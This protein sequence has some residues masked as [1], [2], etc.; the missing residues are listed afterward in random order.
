MDGYG[1]MLWQDACPYVCPSVTRRYYVETA[2]HI[3]KLF[4]PGRHEHHSTVKPGTHWRQ[5]RLLPIRSTLSPMCTGLYGN[6]PTET[7]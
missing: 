5:S 2:K 3:V 1:T 6:I 4:L 7:H